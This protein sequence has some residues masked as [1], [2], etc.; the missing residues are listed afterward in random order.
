MKVAIIGSTTYKIK[1]IDHR[2]N[3]INLYQSLKQPIEVKLPVLDENTDDLNELGICTK[4]REMIEWADEVH[5]LW[6]GRSQ[7]TIF[8]LGMCLAFKK[9]V[10]LV[11]LNPLTLE[12]LVKQMAGVI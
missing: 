3:L 10:Q 2:A 1:M 11:Y 4:N 6:D 12:N 5:V 8:D 9:P 7:G